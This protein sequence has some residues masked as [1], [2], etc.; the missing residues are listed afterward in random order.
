MDLQNVKIAKLNRKLKSEDV[1]VQ[2]EKL[3]AAQPAQIAAIQGIATKIRGTELEGLPFTIALMKAKLLS[4]KAIAEELDIPLRAV[5]KYS[6]VPGFDTLITQL[7]PAIWSDMIL[8]AQATLM[9][10][11]SVEKN[12]EAAKW[13]LEVLGQVASNRPLTNHTHQTLV[14]NGGTPIPGMGG[15]GQLPGGGGSVTVENLAA[16]MMQRLTENHKNTG[17][18]PPTP[19][20]HD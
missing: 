15:V 20:S 4:E 14:L 10:H 7:T 3:Q 6:Q 12:L 18:P 11:I 9:H 17:G 8:A 1:A 5:R 2:L 13:L 16:A 19:L